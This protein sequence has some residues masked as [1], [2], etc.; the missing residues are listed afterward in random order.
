MHL[1][2]ENNIFLSPPFEQDGKWLFLF[3]DKA[4]YK[5]RAFE[6]LDDAESEIRA[7]KCALSLGAGY[8]SSRIHNVEIEQA[9]KITDL[10]SYCQVVTRLL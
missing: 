6:T 2:S 5:F 3:G 7:I 9:K 8:I 4:T 1:F 10:S